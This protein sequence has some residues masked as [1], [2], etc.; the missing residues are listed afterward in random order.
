MFILIQTYVS[1]PAI[2]AMGIKANNMHIATE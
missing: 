1:Q 2:N